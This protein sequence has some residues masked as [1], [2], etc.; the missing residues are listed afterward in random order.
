MIIFFNNV[1]IAYITFLIY[2][3]IIEWWFRTQ[4]ALYEI[5]IFCI[6]KN[7]VESINKLQIN[8]KLSKLEY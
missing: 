4:C 3:Q 1:A 5:H 6:Y 2:F 7:I 8:K